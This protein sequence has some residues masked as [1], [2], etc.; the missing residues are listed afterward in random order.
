MMKMRRILLGCRITLREMRRRSPGIDRTGGFDD[1][2]HD[3]VDD[4]AEEAGDGAAQRP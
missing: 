1:T 3:G 2:H 4:P